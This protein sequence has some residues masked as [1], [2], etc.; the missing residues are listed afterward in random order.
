MVVMMRQTTSTVRARSTEK[1][2]Q[3]GKDLFEE[4]P[5]EGHLVTARDEAISEDALHTG[6]NQARDT[7]DRVQTP[8]SACLLPIHSFLLGQLSRGRQHHGPRIHVPR[9]PPGRAPSCPAPWSARGARTRAPEGPWM[10]AVQGAPRRRR[11]AMTGLQRS[12]R[13]IERRVRPRKT[14]EQQQRACQNVPLLPASTR[15]AAPLYSPRSFRQSHS[16]PRARP[17]QCRNRRGT[18]LVALRRHVRRRAG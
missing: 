3:K 18:L 4:M 2:A 1:G 11:R 15:P 10:P 17:A 12:A 16:R 7:F 14:A 13:W 8:G 6:Q 5:I 9:A